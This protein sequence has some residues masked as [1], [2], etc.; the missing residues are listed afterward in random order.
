[1]TAVEVGAEEGDG[2]GG[3]VANGADVVRARVAGHFDVRMFKVKSSIQW[4]EIQPGG[5]G[6]GGEGQRR[7]T[8]TTLSLSLSQGACFIVWGSGIGRL[9]NTSTIS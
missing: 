5:R 2:R 9:W 8:R 6:A 1:M 4:G 3:I 7:V